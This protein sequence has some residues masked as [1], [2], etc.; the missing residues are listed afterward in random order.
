MFK[1][2]QK[3]AFANKSAQK[4]TLKST[5]GSSEPICCIV[6]IYENLPC[7]E[8]L[9]EYLASLDIPAASQS[10]EGGIVFKIKT[11][12]MMATPATITITCIN[13]KLRS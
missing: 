10:H 11:A 5:F 7:R 1:K 12:I 2:V 13:T 6:C 4:S 3:S 9:A 8:L